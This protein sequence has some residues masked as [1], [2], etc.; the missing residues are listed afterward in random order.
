M[1]TPLTRFPLPRFAAQ[2]LRERVQKC[3]MVEGVNHNQN[4][5]EVRVTPRPRVHL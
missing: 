1:H 2:L 5:K 3:Y 4:C